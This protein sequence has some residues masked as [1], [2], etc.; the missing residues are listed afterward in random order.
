MVIIL[1]ASSV[2]KSLRWKTCGFQTFSLALKQYV[3]G[4][5]GVNRRPKLRYQQKTVHKIFKNKQINWL[6]SG[7]TQSTTR[8]LRIIPILKISFCQ[9]VTSRNA[10]YTTVFGIVDCQK[11]VSKDILADLKTLSTP[12]VNV[13][14]KTGTEVRRFSGKSLANSIG[15]TTSN[16]AVWKYSGITNINS[17]LLLHKNQ[18]TP[19]KQRAAKM[20]KQAKKLKIKKLFFLICKHVN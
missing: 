12:V 16:Y 20:S 10:G 8:S 19:T 15:Y 3:Q 11:D 6:T 2:Q 1:G 4:Y 5:F 13:V 18:E 7:P 9:S 17:K 14:F